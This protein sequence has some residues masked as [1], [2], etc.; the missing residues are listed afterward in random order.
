MLTPI[1]SLLWCQMLF[2]EM[3]RTLPYQ[4][5]CLTNLLHWVGVLTYLCFLS[6][7]FSLPTAHNSLLGLLGFRCSDWELPLFFPWNLSCPKGLDLNQWRFPRTFFCILSW[8]SE[9]PQRDLLITS[10]AKLYV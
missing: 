8:T 4:L 5:D 6:P 7:L 9:I 3:T 1:L 10:Q 2:P